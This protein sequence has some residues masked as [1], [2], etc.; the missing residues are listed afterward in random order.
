MK[1]VRYVYWQDEDMWLGYVEDFP[2]CMT[3]AQT[4]EDLQENLKDLYEDLTG[5]KIPGARQVAELRIA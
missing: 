5:G 4:L 3:Q 1:T 2:D